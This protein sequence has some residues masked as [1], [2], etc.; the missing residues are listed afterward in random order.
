MRTD[1][2]ITIAGA[3]DARDAASRLTMPVRDESCRAQI[4]A[5]RRR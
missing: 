3:H 2:L 1:A 5:R 4:L